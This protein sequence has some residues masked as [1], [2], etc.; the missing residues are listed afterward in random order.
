MS[1]SV[2]DEG[3]QRRTSIPVVVETV[4]ETITQWIKKWRNMSINFVIMMLEKQHVL[5]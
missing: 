5:H 1:D 4:G 2:N 3:S